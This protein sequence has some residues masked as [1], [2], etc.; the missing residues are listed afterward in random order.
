MTFIVV[1]HF[2]TAIFIAWT[3][4]NGSCAQLLAGSAKVPAGQSL[5]GTHFVLV[6]R[7][8]FV[9]LTLYVH[10]VPVLP[11]GLQQSAPTY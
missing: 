1:T 10:T 8:S 5:S 11:L 2:L 4:D 7:S 9:Y 3:S 6:S